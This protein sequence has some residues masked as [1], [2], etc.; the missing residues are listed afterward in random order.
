MSKTVIH[1]LT[2]FGQ[3][4][5]LDNINRFLIESGKLGQMIEMGLSGLT[6]N[7]TIFDKA[8]SESQ[9]YD[10]R[11]AQFKSAGKST[12]EIYDDLTVRDIQDAA[13]MFG[14]VYKSSGGLNGYV[15]LEVDPRIASDTEATLKEAQRLY[16]KVNRPNV[17]FKI[18]ATEEGFPAVE[19][20]LALGININVTLIFSVE[21]YVKT[22]QIFL[23]GLEK[24]SRNSDDLSKTASVASVFV[25]RVDSVIDKALDELIAREEDSQ[26]KTKLISLK[27]K[28]AVANSSLIYKKSKEILSTEDFKRLATKK[29]RLQRVLWA[30]TSTKNPGYNDIKYVSELIVKN[31]VNTLPGNTYEAFL[32]HGNVKEALKDNFKDAE[33]IIND[34]MHI[35]IDVNKVCEKLLKD[36]VAAFQNSFSSLLSSIEKK[37][38]SLCLEQNARG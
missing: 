10:A 11:I 15:S 13:D 8:I 17:M 4:I 14:E 12:F 30:S 34:L 31:T 35:G 32:D 27:G 29:A 7:P 20:L 22:A 18:P 26:K 36:G 21:Q 24:L 3:S 1:K 2:D 38:D 9:S 28:A 5:W 16:R 6:S 25:S 37:A 19:E 33:N 23:R